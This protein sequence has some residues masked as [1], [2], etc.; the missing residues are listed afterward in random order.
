MKFHDVY[1]WSQGQWTQ[2]VWEKLHEMM[3]KAELDPDQYFYTD[4][5]GYQLTSYP[6]P[7]EADLSRED[8]IRIAKD[9]LN[10]DRAA[11]DSAVLTEY[12]G[13]RTW[14]V[15]LLVS[16]PDDDAHPE[17]AGSYV[18][19]LDSATGTVMSLRKATGDDS[20]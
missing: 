11:L 3:Q 13:E 2:T 1:S 4:C 6:D 5:R 12:A 15:A 10:L 17:K 9:R 19:T 20:L 8:A 16:L 14:M 7:G 18:I